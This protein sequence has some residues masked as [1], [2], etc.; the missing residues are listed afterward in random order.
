M[1]EF[2][3]TL[4]ILAALIAL[5]LFAIKKFSRQMSGLHSTFLRKTLHAATETP[6]RGVVVGTLLTMLVQSSGAISVLSVTLAD[7]GLVTFRNTLG[8]VFGA[9]LG[10]TFSSQLF[11]LNITL[12]A[13]FIVLFGFFLEKT[14]LRSAKYG[15]AIFYFGLLYFALDLI[16]R[17]VTP[18]SENPL[19]TNLFSSISSMPVA[20]VVGLLVT[21]LL[22]SSSL[23][24][25][26]TIIVA[27]TGLLSLPYAVGILLGA[28]VGTTSSSLLASFPLARTAKKVSMAHFLYNLLGNILI[29]PFL[30]FIYPLLTA[31]SS[32]IEHQ[33]VIFNVGFN[34]LCALLG[35][36]FVKQFEK[37]V[38]RA[39]SLVYGK[40]HKS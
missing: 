36:I 6:L 18:L 17:T 34:L 7:A 21:I 23:V 16:V 33:L 30:P 4:S 14:S 5:F 38:I 24:T 13:P 20:V 9:N 32:S 10:T 3:S 40:E 26:L 39:T 1:S 11:A 19:I 22:Q 31:S 29:Y 37:I 35:L 15:R 12:L 28:N 25:L 8:V 27:G 2:T